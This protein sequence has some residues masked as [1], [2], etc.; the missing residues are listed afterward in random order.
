MFQLYNECKM[1]HFCESVLKILLPKD[2]PLFLLLK[3][4]LTC[5]LQCLYLKI[6]KTILVQNKKKKMC[7]IQK[8]NFTQIYG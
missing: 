6:L 7:L 5:S 3:V 1:L 4:T 8:P 2:Y